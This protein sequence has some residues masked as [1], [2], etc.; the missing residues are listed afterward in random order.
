MRRLSLD[1]A[2]DG[3]LSLLTVL[4][5]GDGV[6]GWIEW[7]WTQLWSVFEGEGKGGSQGRENEV[8]SILFPS[9]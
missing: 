1:C 5:M 4:V 3:I 2:S 6:V 8:K 7:L 9:Q